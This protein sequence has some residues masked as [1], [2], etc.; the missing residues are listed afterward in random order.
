MIAGMAANQRAGACM[1]RVMVISFLD[2]FAVPM[3][4]P[5]TG[6]AGRH[7]CVCVCVVVF[8]WGG[9]TGQEAASKKKSLCRNF[10]LSSAVCRSL[11]GSLAGCMRQSEERALSGER[12]R[13][14]LARTRRRCMV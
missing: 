9:L 11:A 1:S 7:V 2:L 8:C 3:C 13:A 12:A 14:R 6:G 5:T 4:Q 10:S